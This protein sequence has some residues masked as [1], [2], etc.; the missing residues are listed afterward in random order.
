MKLKRTV[1]FVIL[2]LVSLF[3]FA[4]IKTSYPVV[5]KGTPGRAQ[6][7]SGQKSALVIHVAGGKNAKYSAEQYAKMLQYMFKSSKHTSTPTDISVLYEESDR[8]HTLALVSSNG[9]SFDRNGGE[10]K[11]GDGVYFI[12]DIVADIE[13]ITAHHAAKKRNK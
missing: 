13:K 4:Q 8:N 2:C 1:P 6:T 3:S 9:R 10:Y 5:E 12:N 11:K 7:I